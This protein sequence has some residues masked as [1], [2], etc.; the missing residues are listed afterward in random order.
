MQPPDPR[1]VRMAITGKY[2]DPPGGYKLQPAAN[3][4]RWVFCSARL[5]TRITHAGTPLDMRMPMSQS[6]YM[7]TFVPHLHRRPT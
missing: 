3:G 6:E 2:E 5:G 4:G 7:T 1:I